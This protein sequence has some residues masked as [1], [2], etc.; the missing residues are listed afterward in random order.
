L[1]VNHEPYSAPQVDVL[2]SL[3]VG[4]ESE[5]GSSRRYH[6]LFAGTRQ[7][8]RTFE[9]REVLSALQEHVQR[10]IV[11]LARDW[12]FVTGGV[13]GWH[14]RAIVLVGDSAAEPIAALV[15]RGATYYSS[16]YAVFDRDG[17]LYPFHTQRPVRPEMDYDL[18]LTPY[19]AQPCP[20]PLGLMVVAAYQIQAR[21]RPRHLTSAQ[22]LLALVAN[23]QSAAS[24]PAHAL[25]MLRSLTTEWKALRGN[26]T[27]TSTFS[28]SLL[29]RLPEISDIPSRASDRLAQMML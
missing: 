14:N 3:I 18:D 20:L 25:S 15:Q 19:L 16:Q 6:L 23:A 7:I 2:Y 28:R 26:W 27:D 10:S 11:A 12:L 17:F 5:S 13:V 24:D 1:P 22:A 8:A 9:W 29:S 21:W 4:G